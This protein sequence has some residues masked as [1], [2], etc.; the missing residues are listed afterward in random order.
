MAISS[1]DAADLAQN[2]TH[3]PPLQQ[4][5]ARTWM[6]AVRPHGVLPVMPSP[7]LLAQFLEPSRPQERRQELRSL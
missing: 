2:T 5:D 1:L 4:L 6:P 3:R 7:P